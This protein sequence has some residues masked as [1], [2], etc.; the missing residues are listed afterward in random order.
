MRLTQVGIKLK[1]AYIVTTQVPYSAGTVGVTYKVSI[2]CV[3]VFRIIN[4][5]ET[6][7]PLF[8]IPVIE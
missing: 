4:D 2:A 7:A 6:E 3:V 1:Q 5:G 8:V